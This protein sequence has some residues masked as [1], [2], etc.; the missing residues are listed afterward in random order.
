[1]RY[2]PSMHRIYIWTWSYGMTYS[3]DGSTIPL[4]PFLSSVIQPGVRSRGF[5]L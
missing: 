5:S 1:M 4:N 3:L 2:E